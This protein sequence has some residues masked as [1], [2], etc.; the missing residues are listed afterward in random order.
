MKKIYLENERQSMDPE[1]ND[2]EPMGG[3]RNNF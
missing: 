1:H 3:K 2:M